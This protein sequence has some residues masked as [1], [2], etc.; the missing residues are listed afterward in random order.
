MLYE[1]VNTEYLKAIA[2][3]YDISLAQPAKDVLREIAELE[4]RIG[5]VFAEV[6]GPNG[7]IREMLLRSH[8]I[9]PDSTVLEDDISLRWTGDT[10]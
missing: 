5:M 10:T 9:H 4:S 1:I 6:R 3:T 2:T 7:E 8:Y